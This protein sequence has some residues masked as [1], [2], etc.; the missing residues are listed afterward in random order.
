MEN[1]ENTDSSRKY[2]NFRNSVFFNFL[3][4]SHNIKLWVYLT[5]VPERRRGLC[6]IWPF[7]T[8]PCHHDQGRYYSCYRCFFAP[9]RN[10]HN[11]SSWRSKDDNSGSCPH[12][13]SRRIF[14]AWLQLDW[15]LT[16][17]TTTTTDG[18]TD[19]RTDGFINNDFIYYQ[20][21]IY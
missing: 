7:P 12:H 17:F 15:L 10:G 3:Y 20:I 8:P 2:R 13:F 6:R 14:W 1:P 5:H 19:G 11:S 18:R 16:L 9:H 4:F 21:Y